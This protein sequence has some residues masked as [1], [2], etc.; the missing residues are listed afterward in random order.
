MPEQG[1]KFSNF[2]IFNSKTFAGLTRD[3]ILL[4]LTSLF[5]DVSTEM[6]YP[7]L[8]VYLTQYLNADGS[9][10]GLIEGVAQSTQNITQGFSGYLSDKFQRH[11]SI[12]LAGY[13]L[14]AIS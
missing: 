9:I 7:I 4:A 10:I 1:N 2:Q 6:L 3:T 13:F 14:A 11:K 8:P 12:A 5:A